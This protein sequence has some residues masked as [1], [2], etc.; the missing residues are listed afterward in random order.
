M[1]GIPVIGSRGA[2]IDE[3]VE[4]DRTGHLVALGD[5]DSLAEALTKM[6]LK[7]SPVRK[8]FAWNSDISKDMQ[9]ERAVS[10]LLALVRQSFPPAKERDFMHRAP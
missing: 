2:S 7:R 8:G 4:E 3:L 6:W 9:P 5:I 10:N 1:F